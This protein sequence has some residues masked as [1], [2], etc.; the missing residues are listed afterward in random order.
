[1][2]PPPPRAPHP[3]HDQGQL[4]GSSAGGG[5]IWGGAA[6]DP[7]TGLGPP[8]TVLGVG[9]CLLALPHLGP[10]PCPWAPARTLGPL[11]APVGLAVPLR[12]PLGWP[13]PLGPCS[14]CPACLCRPHRQRARWALAPATGRRSRAARLG[15]PRRASCTSTATRGRPLARRRPCPRSSPA[16]CRGLAPGPEGVALGPVDRRAMP[17]PDRPQ[18]GPRCAGTV[19]KAGPAE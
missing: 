10:C 7:N 19:P 14:Q 15:R 2:A 4:G 16:L 13:V 5:L 18:M 17:G 1:M 9:G 12:L 3:K 8:S 11:P 6:V